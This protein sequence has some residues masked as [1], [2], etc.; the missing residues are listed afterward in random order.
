[1]I[2]DISSQVVERG[3]SQTPRERVG[4]MFYNRGVYEGVLIAEA[5]RNA[6]RLSG[7]RVITTED[8]RRGLEALNITAERWTELGL[9][10][11][12]SPVRV[13]CT[14]HNGH[15]ALYFVQWDGQ[16]WQR[17][18]DW[19]QPLREVVRPLIDEAAQQYATQNQG[20]PQRSAACD[21]R[22]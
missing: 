11:F 9:P 1:L 10:E 21:E 14:D 7:R 6:Q 5:I 19:I 12:A 18:S 8:M 20:W 17:N 22:S 3:Q 2:R 15:H 4:E 16:R 13:T